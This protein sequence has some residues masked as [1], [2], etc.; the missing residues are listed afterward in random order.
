[1][2]M[3]TPRL[4]IC[5]GSGAKTDTNPMVNDPAKAVPRNLKLRRTERGRCWASGLGIIATFCCV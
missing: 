2:L 3:K 5:S 1:M 4:A